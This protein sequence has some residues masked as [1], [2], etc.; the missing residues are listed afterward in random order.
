MRFTKILLFAVLTLLYISCNILAQNRR[1]REDYSFLK[2][3]PRYDGKTDAIAV[4]RYDFVVT[5]KT[6]I[7]LDA[8]KFIP[9]GTPPAGGWPT[10][11]YV[12][13]FGDSKET[14]AGF[15][16]AQAEYGYY[17]AAFSVRGQGNSTGLS[18]LISNIEAQDLIQFVDAIKKD[19]VNGSAPGNILIMGGSQG[20]ILP[21]MASCMG[22][23]VKTI[24]SALA[25]P[26]FASSWI[27]NGSIKM[28]LL[29]TVEY[30]TDTARYTPLV[31]RM[32][33]WIYA[34]NIQYWDSLAYWLPPGRDFINTVGN[35]TVPLIMEGSWQDKFF[36]A[37]GIIK[38]AGL[39]TGS[40][41][42]L[43]LGAVQGH[44]GDHSDTEDQWHMN[45]FNEWFFYWL[46]NQNNG[47]LSKPKYE[48][49][50]TTYPV[51]NNYWTF[52]HDSLRSSFAGFTANYRLHF[53]TGGRLTKTA[54]TVP[55]QRA[56]LRN[57]VTG[58]LTMQEAVNEEFTGSV[59]NSKFVKRKVTF[60]T[61]PLTAD[62]K[63]LGTPKINLNYSSTAKTFVQFNFQ[64]FELKPDGTQRLINR[65]NYT[66]RNYAANQIRTKNFEG[67]AHS[68]IFKAGDRIKIVVT[69]LDT[70]PEDVPFFGTNPFV[71]PTLNNGYHYINLNSN[72]YIDIPV[73]NQ[74]SAPF[75]EEDAL[76]SPLRYSLEQ[77]YP[78][79]F[80]P[81]TNI[82]FTIPS[83]GIFT[84]LKVY[85]IT[86][87][88][89]KS[90]I[91]Q[92]LNQGIYEIKFE[93][94]NLSSGVYFYTLKA[95]NYVDTKKMLLVK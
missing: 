49:A 4:T 88:E 17:T 53:N 54:N 69:N 92:N 86:G 29:W 31:D 84:E 71:L 65:I 19:S 41:F 5:T 68:H 94:Y 51:T 15:A 81:V 2:L 8:L 10:V 70:S 40:F 39:N 90:L 76:N 93:G 63:W 26:N 57:Q 33:D 59:F 78:N 42:R 35:N 95:G 23:K 77:N 50:S 27:E 66:D 83:D 82:K 30:P 37:S 7:R 6:G 91:N 89:V 60:T 32:S 72:S 12:H 48:Y 74:L 34:N 45:F 28:T 18:N 36:N 61:T 14:L 1:A 22:M 24:I 11:I 64:I 38:A 21:Y 85:N 62:L 13:G 46:F 9:T 56:Q 80:N 16:Q 73:Y 75:V 58:G 43:Y 55:N 25:P 20:G 52:V 87:Q 47:M 44:G 3:L 79:P 67:Q